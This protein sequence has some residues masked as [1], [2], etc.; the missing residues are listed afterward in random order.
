VF[1]ALG[2]FSSVWLPQLGFGYEHV[3][4]VDHAP[5]LC[6]LGAMKGHLLESICGEQ[7]VVRGYATP[8]FKLNIILVHAL[9]L[10]DFASE[11]DMV[12]IPDSN[13]FWV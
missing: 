12:G 9:Y 10:N 6:A 7:H 8:H 3:Y 13:K 11:L 4:V 1:I 5:N 2:P